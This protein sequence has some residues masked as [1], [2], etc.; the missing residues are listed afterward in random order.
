MSTADSL[1]RDY[2]IGQLGTASAS[3]RHLD[4]E[5]RTKPA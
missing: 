4:A 2:S 1:I 5:N 3:G